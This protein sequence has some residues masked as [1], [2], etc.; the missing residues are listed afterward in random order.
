MDIG[1]LKIKLAFTPTRQEAKRATFGTPAWHSSESTS[2][3]FVATD[4]SRQQLLHVAHV[5]I[6][7]EI[8]H[9][10]DVPVALEVVHGLGGK[11]GWGRAVHDVKLVAGAEDYRA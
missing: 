3:R 4:A 8:F 9:V 7:L 6:V 5:P 2:R 1:S 11:A 10:A